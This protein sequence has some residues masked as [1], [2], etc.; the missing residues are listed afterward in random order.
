MAALLGRRLDDEFILRP[1]PTGAPEALGVDSHTPRWYLCHV[2]GLYE[3]RM[4]FDPAIQKLES[5][6]VLRFFAERLRSA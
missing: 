6:K 5:P 4:A 3:G 2:S 1:P